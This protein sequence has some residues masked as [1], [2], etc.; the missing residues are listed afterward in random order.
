MALTHKWTDKCPRP[1]RGLW[2]DLQEAGQGET[3]HSSHLGESNSCCHPWE[4]ISDGVSGTWKW[5]LQVTWQP[6]VKFLPF[7]NRS[8]DLGYGWNISISRGKEMRMSARD[9]Q[10][11]QLSLYGHAKKHWTRFCVCLSPWTAESAGQNGLHT[12]Q[13]CSLFYGGK[14]ASKR[15]TYGLGMSSPFFCSFFLKR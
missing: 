15:S 13:G 2:V 4:M 6:V 12:S 8:L 14:K 1:H 9:T 10:S 3:Q 11:C 7:L 5:F